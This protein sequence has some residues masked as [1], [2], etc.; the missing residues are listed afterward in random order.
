MKDFA[1]IKRITR[2]FSYILSKKQKKQAAFV[3][4]L[5]IIGAM[6]ELL[7]VS[8]VLPFIQ[9]F[10][11]PEELMDKWYIKPVLNIFEINEPDKLLFCFGFIIIIVYIF[12]NLF[13]ALV[14]Y[15]RSRFSSRLQSSL[16]VEM[17]RSYLDRPYLFFVD[18]DTGTLLHGVNMD[19]TGVH[20]FILTFFKFSS[21]VLVVIFIFAYLMKEDKLLSLGLMILAALCTIIL[22]L[23]VKKKVYRL[24]NAMREAN[25]K[26]SGLAVQ[27]IN[28]IK[29]IIVFNKKKFFTRQY[30][31]QCRV[32]SGAQAKSE[33]IST[34][35]E[36]IIEATCVSGIIL[37]IIIKLRIGTDTKSFISTMSVFAM[38][39]FRILPSISKIASYTQSFV[40]N[41]PMVEA[42]FKN[43]SEARAYKKEINVNISESDKALNDF[44]QTVSIKN[45]DWKYEKGKD[46]VLNDL[47]L[48]IN[49]GDMIGLIG[50][51]GSG[52][53]TLGDMLLALY[54][55]QAGQIC[56][57]GT[58]I[59]TIPSTWRNVISYVPQMLMLFN[60]SIRFNIIFS[61]DTSED[62]KVWKVIKEASLEEYIK[63]LPEGLDTQVGDRGIKLSGGQRQR[64]A[65]A[66]ALYCNPQILLLDEAT[67]ALDNETETAVVESIN[68]LSKKITL[69]VIA[70]RISTLKSCNKI[71]EIIDGKA[72]EVD[73]SILGL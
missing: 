58:D 4:V 15:S 6:F 52:K 56:M 9:A 25:K 16:T 73:K 11:D 26:R 2:Y 19:V 41:R 27:I 12:K 3:L 47:S 43:I 64:I 23:F 32:F 40:K 14:S 69:I 59:S 46:K 37:F 48:D 66:R 54:T 39:A 29:D 22:T 1:T 49:K 38:G 24:S 45:I 20:D 34:L 30:E 31:D 62:E 13:L 67:S 21:E 44:K 72:S 60:A 7:G 33:F 65:I 8:I 36:R 71:Y 61:D 51:S 10:L 18:S 42:T 28:N 50:E 55:P 35:P 57:D 53:S 70:H 17:L 5:V 68:A 63:N